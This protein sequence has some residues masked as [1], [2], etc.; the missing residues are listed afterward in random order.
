MQDYGGIQG[1]SHSASSYNKV[2]PEN[3][4]L[5]QIRS[6][7][8]KNLSRPE[9]VVAHQSELLIVP[10]CSGNGGISVISPG[11]GGETHHILATSADPVRPNGIAL[12]NGGTV[13]LAHMGES[14]GGIYRL[15]PNGQIETVLTSA[16]GEPIPR[17]N[18]IVL[19]STGRLWITVSTRKIPRADDYRADAHSGF[20]AVAEPGESDA[21]IVADNLGYTNECVIDEANSCV[22]V[23]E[24]F[25]RRLSR[26]SLRKAILRGGD[27]A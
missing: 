22:W 20:I 27:K 18:F 19:D 12:E 15:F 1:I 25:G 10:N 6:W 4:T 16:N 24:T 13:L 2:I 7:N 9:C 17:T 8:G 23:N 14:S 11:G 5:G 3:N 26:L 21:R